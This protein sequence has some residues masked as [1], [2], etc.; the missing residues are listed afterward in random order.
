MTNVAFIRLK[1][2]GKKFELACYRNKALNWRSKTETD[3]NE[4]LQIDKIFT[5]ASKGEV[6]KKSDL[7]V[8]GEDLTE[9]EIIIE[10]LNKG[11]MHVSDLEREDQHQNLRK[12]ITNIISSKCIN[13]KDNNQF[14]VSIILK[15]M[16]EV[17]VKIN[18]T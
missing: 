10:I 17:N 15:A 9:Q 13:T 5:N 4:V 8:F 1:K 3:I 7:K 18:P 14:P 2:G 12:D 11:D 16:T 6:A